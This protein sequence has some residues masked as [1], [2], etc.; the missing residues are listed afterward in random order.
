MT[1]FD[2]A[3]QKTL[4]LEGGFVDDPRDPGGATNRGITQAVYDT[5]RRSVGAGRKSVATIA[6]DEV[7]AIYKARY[8]ALINGDA[9]PVGVGYV[10]FD[11]AVNSGPAQSAKWLQRALGLNKA[12]GLIGPETLAAVAAVDDHDLLIARILQIR[13][14]FLRALKTWK[15][16]GR[17]WR[18][19]LA[20]VLA[21]GQAWARGSVGPEVVHDADGAA[22]ARATDAR[23]APS[24]V[25]GDMVAGGGM[26]TGVSLLGILAGAKDQLLPLAGSSQAIT[27]IVAGVVI[28]T[29]VVTAAGAA[30]SWWAIRRRSRLAEALA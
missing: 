2:R 21:V 7:T 25:A 10:V 12:D 3:L 18:N 15:R 26:T 5:Y 23:A 9:L 13:E 1:E 29:A 19:R 17:G 24:P 11:G 4:V 22:K 8:W 28:A 14:R 6:A 20:Q 27:N 30:W 16:F